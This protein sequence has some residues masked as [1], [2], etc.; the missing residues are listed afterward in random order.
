MQLYY[1]VFDRDD[2]VVCF[3]KA[4]HKKKQQ[5]YVVTEDGP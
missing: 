4:D 3:A 5:N 2:D 1:T